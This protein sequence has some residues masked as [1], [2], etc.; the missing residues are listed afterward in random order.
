M[1]ISLISGLLTGAAFVN[2]AFF[3]LV[4]FSLVPF[5]WNLRQAQN[6]GQAAKTALLFAVPF[7]AVVLWWLNELNNFV[8]FWS[9]LAYAALVGYQSL[10]FLLFGVVA[11]YLKSIKRI[12]WIMTWPAA[13]VVV[14]YLRTL[15]PYGVSAGGLGYSQTWAL[16]ML[17]IAR[18]TGVF[19][20]SFFL[21]VVNGLILSLVVSR[22]FRAVKLLAL[23]ALVAANF[24]FGSAVIHS[25]SAAQNNLPTVKL[26]LVQGGVPQAE[27]LQNWNNDYYFSIYR[28]L[29]CGAQ[30]FHPQIYVW[31]ETAFNNFIE[32]RTTFA[33]LA[34]LSKDLDAGLIMGAP[35]AGEREYF[36]SAYFFANGKPLRDVYDKQVLVPFAEYLPLRPI[37]YP[38]LSSTRMYESDYAPG[39][40]ATVFNLAGKRIGLLICFESTF[41]NPSR[42]R[43]KAGADFLLT[44]TN[45]AWFGK[46]FGL[47]QH[48]QA[49]VLRAVENG[50]YFVQAANT[51][52]S[53]AVDGVGC[54]QACSTVNAAQALIVKVKPR[55]G[56]TFYSQFGDVFVLVCFLGLAGLIAGQKFF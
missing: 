34:A 6:Y 11:H 44:L 13:F 35:R 47:Q 40:G 19:G 42:E 3:P 50:A 5:L 17:Q 56:L 15:G 32:G 53:A 14:D 49:G 51:G 24:S 31:P 37:T 23:A 10:L 9:T 20:I 1:W 52:L 54:I 30:A 7:F 16:P 21:L 46:S 38:V 48:L 33:Q 27:R 25:Y 22:R 8:P 39:K 26:A 36:N 55:T 28:R 41:P 43:V 12:S 45:D 2:P 29:S 4:Y 18:F